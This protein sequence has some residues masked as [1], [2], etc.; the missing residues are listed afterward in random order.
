MSDIQDGYRWVLPGVALVG[1]AA[2]VAGGIVSRLSDL[3]H[4]IGAA[5]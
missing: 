1:T 4:D 2:I 3:L 5:P